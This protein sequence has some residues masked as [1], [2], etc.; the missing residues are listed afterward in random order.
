[1]DVVGSIVCIILFSPVML[2]S[3]ILVKATS[4]GPLIFAQERVGLH[5]KPFQMYKFRTMYVQT[6]EEEQKGW[7]KKNDPRVTGVGKFLRKTRAS[8]VC[9]EI[10]GRDPEIYDQASGASGNDRLGS[11][12][13]IPWRHV[14]PQAH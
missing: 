5:N 8:A 12:Q 11:G 3:A 10:P 13:R 7:T 2:L 9:R 6:E 14:D 4:K 1:M